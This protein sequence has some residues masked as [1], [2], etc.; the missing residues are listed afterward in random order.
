M[1]EIDAR[2][3]RLAH[4]F[5]KRMVENG[6]DP[7]DQAKRQEQAFLDAA[8]TR[9]LPEEQ[10]KELDDAMA[11]MGIET[12]DKQHIRWAVLGDMASIAE[13]RLGKAE[14]RLLELE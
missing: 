3:D 8:E 13:S 7:K 6:W 11:K 9:D 10:Q 5:D 4:E 12:K 1:F 2:Q 14:G